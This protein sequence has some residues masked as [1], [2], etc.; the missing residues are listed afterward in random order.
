MATHS[1]YTGPTDDETLAVLRWCDDH[2]PDGFV[3]WYPLVHPQLG[4]VELGGW[5]ELSTW[6]NPPLGRLR[7]EVAAHADFAIHQA[8]CSPRL[9]IPHVRVDRL[10]DDL[11]RVEAGV[12]N[13]GWLPTDVSVQARK[14][15]LVAPVT[16]ELVPD[17]EASIV[18]VDGPARRRHGQL[19][20]R[21]DLRFRGGNDGTPDRILA[22]WTVGGPAGAVG[23]IVAAHDR[24]GRTDEE[25]RL[26]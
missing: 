21:A 13:T 1:W 17:A 16:V 6:T 3:D 15:Q 25:F 7:D 14:E 20:G 10:A 26:G 24:C 2:H 12:A 4:E 5:D 9:E 22:S 8:L 19:A 23:T 11:W 18:V